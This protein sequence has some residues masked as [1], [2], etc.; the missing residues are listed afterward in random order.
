MACANKDRYRS[1]I[2]NFRMTIEEAEELDAKVALSG[3]PKQKYI[4]DCVLNHRVTVVNMSTYTDNYVNPLDLDVWSLGPNDSKGQIREKGEFMLGLCE[5]CM[6]DSLNSR[7]KSIID[8]CVRKMYTDIARSREK[9]VPI[10][11]DFY[12]ILMQQPEAE[13]KDIAL[14]LELFR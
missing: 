10:M 4:A 2:V 5:Q 1:K 13:A 6:G 11:S 12:D 14:S 9:Y 7:P 3:L 8:R